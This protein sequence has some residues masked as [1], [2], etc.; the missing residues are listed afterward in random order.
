MDQD[1]L[2]ENNETNAICPKTGNWYCLDHPA[3]E[4]FVKEGAYFPKCRH[5][6]TLHYASWKMV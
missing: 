5:G 4:I 6:A 1:R 3:V 2:N